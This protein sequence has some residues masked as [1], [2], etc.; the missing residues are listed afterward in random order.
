MHKKN[1]TQTHNDKW[2]KETHTH[3][4][5]QRPSQTEGV[6]NCAKCQYYKLVLILY[7]LI[8]TI[9]E[10]RHYHQVLRC[11][12]FVLV[13]LLKEPHRQ[14]V[15]TVHIAIQHSAENCNLFYSL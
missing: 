12:A 4:H 9:C 8:H 11:T 3:T 15:C 7:K 1:E 6:E 5:T 13:S 10:V 2:K 14:F